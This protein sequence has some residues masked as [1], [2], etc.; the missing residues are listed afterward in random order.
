MLFIKQVH[1]LTSFD[2]TDLSSLTYL[3][4]QGNL[5]TS[6]DV[7]PLV[8]LSYLRLHQ[9]GWREATLTNPITPLSNNQILF[10]LSQHSISNGQFIST[11]GRTSAS[12]TNYDNLVS[13]GWSLG[14][15][16]LITPP[17]VG[18]RRCRY[19]THWLWES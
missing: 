17:V 8:V 2:G 12:N 10:D 11:G 13:L 14:G 15:L 5:L 19:R 3:V 9:S 4:L 18:N 16:D 6:L 1:Q 7:S